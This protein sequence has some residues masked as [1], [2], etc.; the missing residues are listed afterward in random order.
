MYRLIALEL[1]NP[2]T[3]KNQALL[4]ERPHPTDWLM[5]F[6]L[7]NR[8]V[9]NINQPTPPASKTFPFLFNQT[10]RH[11]I[12]VHSKLMIVDDDYIILG[13][14]N[15]NDRSMMGDRD[16]EICVGGFQP[17]F[18]T[19][20]NSSARG[21]IHRFRMSLWSEHLRISEYQFL[22]PSSTQCISRIK[23]LAQLNWDR[24]AAKFFFE[25]LAGHLMSYPIAVNQDGD[26]Y[27]DPMYFPDTEG[28]VAGMVSA[29]IP[30][31]ITV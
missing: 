26:I 20:K 2:P 9:N 13:S 21:L 24:Y 10:R 7:G 22:E 28:K 5:F 25:D 11:Q 4:L 6:C 12:Y 14:A 16:T 30:A 29:K 3:D 15:I 1:K 8:E 19:D 31:D 27:S 23:Q 18:T 17:T